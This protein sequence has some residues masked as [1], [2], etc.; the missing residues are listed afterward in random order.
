[1]TLNYS[2]LFL[3][4]NFTFTEFDIIFSQTLLLPIFFYFLLQHPENF[5]PVI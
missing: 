5:R 2:P 4:L 3:Y 1:M